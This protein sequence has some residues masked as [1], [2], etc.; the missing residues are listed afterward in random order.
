MFDEAVRDPA[1]I[2][3]HNSGCLAQ[4]GIRCNCTFARMNINEISALDA[5]AQSELEGQDAKPTNQ[6]KL[7]QRE[8][9]I[10]SGI[11]SFFGLVTEARQGKPSL[12]KPLSALRMMT[13]G[14][15]AGRCFLGPNGVLTKSFASMR[16]AG[17][18]LR[19]LVGRQA[20][21]IRRLLALLADRGGAA[22]PIAIAEAGASARYANNAMRINVPALSAQTLQP[23][24][25]LAG[26]R[27]HVT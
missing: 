18:E 1:I 2:F 16:A 5:A 19:A 11:A 9:M 15:D 20:A 23:S 8:H 24:P 26:R 21:A 4:P 22:A 25:A 13:T 14:D 10:L 12:P 7:D 17:M 27:S 6:I 3:S